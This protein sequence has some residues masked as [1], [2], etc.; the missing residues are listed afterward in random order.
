M[1]SSCLVLDAIKGFLPVIIAINLVRF[2]GGPSPWCPLPFPDAWVLEMPA[3]GQFTVQL[4]HVL[5]ALAAVLGHNY[6]PWIGFEEERVWLPQ[7]ESLS[8]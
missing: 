4:I 8:P 7:R 1:D 5:T 6:S 3:S 2:Q